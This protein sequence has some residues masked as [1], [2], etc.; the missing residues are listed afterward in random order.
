MHSA[1]N[2]NVYVIDPDEAVHDALSELLSATG[3]RVVCFR[4][5]E[6][7]LRFNDAQGTLHGCLLAEA[8]LPGMG[9]L[10]LLRQLQ[11]REIDVSVA[12][13][14]ST[15]NRDIADQALRAGAV[16]V[17][18]K[19]LVGDCLLKFIRDVTKQK[20]ASELDQEGRRHA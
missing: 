4:S 9:S 20:S 2:K 15:A 17:I 5:A 14:T 8:N 3:I 12:V 7:F 18:S 10:A 16:E 1:D 6:N 19:P 11:V 13:L